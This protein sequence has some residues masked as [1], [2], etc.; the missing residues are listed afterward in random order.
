MFDAWK[1]SATVLACG[2]V[3]VTSLLSI[4][5]QPAAPGLARFA[6]VKESQLAPET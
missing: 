2:F 5:C 1:Q 4:A 3:T 6:A